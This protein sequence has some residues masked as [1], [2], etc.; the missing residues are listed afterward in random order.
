VAELGAPQRFNQEEVDVLEAQYAD[1]VSF[2]DISLRRG[3]RCHST[4]VSRAFRRRC[5]LARIHVSFH[6]S[7]ANNEKL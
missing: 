7:K 1:F 6:I 4:E 3:G 2:A 5:G